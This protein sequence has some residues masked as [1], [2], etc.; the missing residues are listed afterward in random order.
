MQRT[1][2]PFSI[3]FVYLMYVLEGLCSDILSGLFSPRRGFSGCLCIDGF[4]GFG[5]EK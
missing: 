1:G 4:I 2:G 5:A 3:S